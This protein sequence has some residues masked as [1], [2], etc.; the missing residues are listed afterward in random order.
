MAIFIHPGAEIDTCVPLGRFRLQ[1]ACGQK[2]YGE[3]DCFGPDTVYGEFEEDF[4][5]EENYTYTLEL[6]GHIDGN[7]HDRAID[8]DQFGA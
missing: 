8:P 3:Q 5:F 1:Y 4:L 7:L 6:I 2:W